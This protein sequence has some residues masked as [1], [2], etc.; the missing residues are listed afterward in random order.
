MRCD[1]FERLPCTHVGTPVRYMR[2][3]SHLVRKRSFGRHIGFPTRPYP[4]VGSGLR[5]V[6]QKRLVVQ[7]RRVVELVRPA[8]PLQQRQAR[9]E[10]AHRV[11]P[12]LTRRGTAYA[13]PS[14]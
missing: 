4:E 14:R 1:S 7:R 3:H 8:S 13:G 12:V 11:L 9:G 10:P 2:G 6:V 5:R